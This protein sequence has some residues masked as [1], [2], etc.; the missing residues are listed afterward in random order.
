MAL[1]YVLGI[2]IRYHPPSASPDHIS[3]T[4][5]AKIET[6]LYKALCAAETRLD[7]YLQRLVWTSYGSIEKPMKL[8]VAFVLWQRLRLACARL[9]HLTKIL[10]TSPGK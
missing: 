6:L 10:A 7:E 4:V 1:S 5:E 9:S 8:P 3:Y 2:G